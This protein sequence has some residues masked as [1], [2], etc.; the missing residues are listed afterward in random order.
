MAPALAR[1]VKGSG[2][3]LFTWASGMQVHVA[4]PSVAT[5]EPNTLHISPLNTSLL[6][7]SVLFESWFI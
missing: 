3:Q 1:I 5:I 2:P 4:A 7:V 6:K